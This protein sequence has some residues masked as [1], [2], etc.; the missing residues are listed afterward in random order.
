[1]DAII[2]ALAAPF[3]STEVKWKPQ[4]VSGNRALAI[5]Y[6]D[7]RVVQDRLDEVI[8]VV[9]WQDTY[10]SL[11]DGTVVCKLSVRLNGEWIS[12]MDV[13]G[14]SEQPDEGDRHKAAFSDALKRAA[15][16][17]G[18]GRY[19]Y[20]QKPQWRDYD[21]QKRQFVG[22]A[23]F[24]PPAPPIASA[25]PTKPIIGNNA[26][27]RVLVFQGKLILAGLCEDGELLDALEDALGQA[28]VTTPP[29]DIER[30]CKAFEQSRKAQRQMA[31]QR[32]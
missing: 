31:D 11:P 8:G 18:V 6:L 2:Q 7:A 14:P 29:V 23:T 12:K 21:P 9:N 20:R 30:A 16:K 5:P 27:D 19:L 25:A 26:L 17:F 13:G 32:A 1:M 22:Q 24:A 3:D 4:A 10:E 15:V 28:W